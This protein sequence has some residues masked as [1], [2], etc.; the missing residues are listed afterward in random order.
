MNGCTPARSRVDGVDNSVDGPLRADE[1]P[2]D[3]A[4]GR[5]RRRAAAVDSAGKRAAA[6]ECEDSDLLA[7]RPA[8]TAA[9]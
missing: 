5:Q 7:M 8:V 3:R 2:V 1:R 6:V 9:G 4:G